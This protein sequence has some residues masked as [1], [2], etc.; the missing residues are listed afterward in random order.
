MSDTA[1]AMLRV[2]LRLD[3]PGHP[4]A[5]DERKPIGAWYVHNGQFVTV[6]TIVDVN[7]VRHEVRR[8]TLDEFLSST[9]VPSRG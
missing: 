7:A 5:L 1:E 6:D 8:L 3:D 2:L 9:Y 4:A